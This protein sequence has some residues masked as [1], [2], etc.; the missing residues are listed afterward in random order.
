MGLHAWPCVC[1]KPAIVCA[2]A[3]GESTITLKTIL[4]L[5]CDL[6]GIDDLGL[7]PTERSIWRSWPKALYG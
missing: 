6:E 7:G 1:F 5:A 4:T 3:K 2:V